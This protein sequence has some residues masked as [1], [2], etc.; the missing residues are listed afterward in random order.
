MSYIFCKVHKTNY[1]DE[2]GCHLW[3]EN[4]YVHLAH[5][6][7][8]P[9]KSHKLHLAALRAREGKRKMDDAKKRVRKYLY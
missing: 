4:D 9:A 2:K 6:D 3:N 1:N 8:L 7:C 5:S